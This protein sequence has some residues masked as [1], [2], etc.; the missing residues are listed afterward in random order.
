MTTLSLKKKLKDKLHSLINKYEKM[1]KNMVG[2]SLIDQLLNHTDFPY[3]TKV[4]VMVFP[5][6]FKV[7][8]IELYDMFQDLVDHLEKFKAHTTLHGFPREI[9][10]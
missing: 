9:A 6:R 2:L 8:K 7:P 4:M 3:S 10:C 1:T 5:P